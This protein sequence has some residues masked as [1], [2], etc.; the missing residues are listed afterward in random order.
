VGFAIEV[1]IAMT[2]LLLPV[3]IH[4]IHFVYE[5]FLKGQTNALFVGRLCILI[6]ATHGVLER[7]MKRWQ[8]LLLIWIWMCNENQ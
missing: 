1:T 8:I 7:S 4:S 5:S 6:G 3:S 2:L